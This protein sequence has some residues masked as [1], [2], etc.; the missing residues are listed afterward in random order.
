[1]LVNATAAKTV[2]D[3]DRASKYRIADRTVMS[4]M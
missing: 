3:S 4:I 2:N 1:M